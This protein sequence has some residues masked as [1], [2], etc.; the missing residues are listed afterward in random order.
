[1]SQRSIACSTRVE[2][3]LREPLVVIDFGIHATPLGYQLYQ[4]FFA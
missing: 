1:L 4:D 2:R 3:R